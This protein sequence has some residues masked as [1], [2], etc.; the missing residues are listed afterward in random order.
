MGPVEKH[1]RDRFGVFNDAPWFKMVVRA[2]CL[3]S[4]RDDEYGMDEIVAGL[5]E[6]AKDQGIEVP[7]WCDDCGEA[8]PELTAKGACA[9][10]KKQ[11]ASYT[12]WVAADAARRESLTP[13]QRKPEDKLHTCLLDGIIARDVQ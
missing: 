13:E 7:F 9:S 12:A 10:C 4:D 5:L 11:Q 2:Y 8:A 6:T 3:A 1:L